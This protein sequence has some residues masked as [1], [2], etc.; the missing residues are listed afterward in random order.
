MANI[1]SD[2][3]I[4]PA[5]SHLS[6][7]FYN[8]AAIV[9]V[10]DV[11]NSA[12]IKSQSLD[13]LSKLVIDRS[14]FDTITYVIRSSNFTIVPDE[15][16]E[17][18]GIEAWWKFNLTN[19]PNSL[20]TN[21][22]KSVSAKIIFDAPQNVL[23]TASKWAG[24]KMLHCSKIII[25]NMMVK[26]KHKVGLNMMISLSPGFI[27]L[28]IIDNGN[29]IYYNNFECSEEG[30]Y[31]YYA[32]M[33]FEQLSLNVEEVNVYIHQNGKA[34]AKLADSISK[35]VRK[36]EL[37]ELKVFGSNPTEMLPYTLLTQ[38]LCV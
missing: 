28:V 35:Y 33:P 13:S 16:Y 19:K 7:E 10:M 21:S 34:A 26:Y 9:A 37:N 22:I 17:N 14:K 3:E 6:V 18:K 2:L 4:D 1:F 25:E 30:E 31:A 5:I 12:L 24:A 36:V 15:L 38:H 23:D 29:F 20:H 27:D 32:L 11:K 8:D